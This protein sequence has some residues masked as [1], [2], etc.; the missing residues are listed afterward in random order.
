MSSLLSKVS[1]NRT[2]NN[3]AVLSI[4]ENAAWVTH[5]AAFRTPAVRVI[6]TLWTLKHTFLV[7]VNA[8]K[9]PTQRY[10]CV[11]FLGGGGAEKQTSIKQQHVGGWKLRVAEEPRVPPGLTVDGWRVPGGSR[12]ERRCWCRRESILQ[13]WSA[14]TE[15]GELRIRFLKRQSAERQEKR[16]TRQD[17]YKANTEQTNI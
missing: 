6:N 17:V 10:S 15:W 11:F 4:R 7:A 3:P 16:S 12:Q 5:E 9:T 1:L 2:P 13:P 8:H 14:E